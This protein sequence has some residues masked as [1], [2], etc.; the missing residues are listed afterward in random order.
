M[1][2][3]FWQVKTHIRGELGDGYRFYVLGA[4][5]TEI[6]R[7][8]RD[9]NALNQG[10]L[11][12]LG[13]L[14]RAW[15]GLPSAI[16]GIPV[17][18]AD[19]DPSMPQEKGVF[20]VNSI[21]GSMVDRRNVAE[22]WLQFGWKFRNLV[23]PRVNLDM[24]QLGEGNLLLECHVSAG[25]SF[26]KQNVVRAQAQINHD[27]TVGNYCFVGPGVT[28]CGKVELANGCFIGAGATVV[29]GVRVGSGAVVGA[30]SVV[31]RDVPDNVTVMGVPARVVSTGS[32][33]LSSTSL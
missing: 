15:K 16:H 1:R 25:V 24:V 22:H 3:K 32:N 27:T 29:P 30:G 6:V 18:Q 10:A 5:D 13:F 14:D 4:G 28:I 21:A 7:L 33:G 12:L 31:V 19:P 8:V 23:H 26:G 20:L 17:V 9:H 2:G 11:N